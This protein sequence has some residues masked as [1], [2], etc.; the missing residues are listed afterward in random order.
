MTL[1]EMNQRFRVI[2]D[3]W[4]VGSAQEQEDYLEELTEM[5]LEL[6]KI[7][8]AESDSASWLARTVDRLSRNMSVAQAQ[9]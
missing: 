8:G 6:A 9:L 3:E 5:R 7:T 4:K 1:D 2:E